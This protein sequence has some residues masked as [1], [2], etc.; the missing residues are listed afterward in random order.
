MATVT[1]ERLVEIR[2]LFRAPDLDGLWGIPYS[3]RPGQQP[4]DIWRAHHKWETPQPGW[5][6]SRQVDI[7]DW[8]WLG[9]AGWYGSM[10]QEEIQAMRYYLRTLPAQAIPLYSNEWCDLTD[11][12]SRSG[13]KRQNE[14]R[15]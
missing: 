10:S 7:S 3:M 5:Y 2:V 8:L 11:L 15:D 14:D 6:G 13:R 1:A 9:Q 4:G 12:Q